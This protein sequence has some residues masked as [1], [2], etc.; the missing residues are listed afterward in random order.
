MRTANR[1]IVGLLLLVGFVASRADGSVQ[2]LFSD[3]FN[4][5]PP[6]VF[7][8]SSTGRLHTLLKTTNLASGTWSAVPSAGPR[9]GVGGTGA[10]RDTNRPPASSFYKLKVELP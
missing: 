6:R 5:L 1:L 10:F 8:A 7:F 9:L 3:N 2:L 4:T